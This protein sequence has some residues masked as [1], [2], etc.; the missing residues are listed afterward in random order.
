MKLFQINVQGSPS[1]LQDTYR[2]ARAG[3]RVCVVGQAPGRLIQLSGKQ[4]L[5]YGGETYQRLP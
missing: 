2:V 5:S 1:F 3:G 4:A